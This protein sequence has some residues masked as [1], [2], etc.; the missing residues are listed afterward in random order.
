M[1]SDAIGS[2]DTEL[3]T[4]A[5]LRR[6]DAFQARSFD[7][8][9]AYRYSLQLRDR[10]SVEAGAYQHF[11]NGVP[12]E[13][14]IDISTMVGCPVQ[15]RFCEAASIPFQRAL[16]P[17]EM[18]AQAVK[19]ARDHDGPSFPRIMCSF[20]GIGEPSLVADSVVEA[21]RYLLKHDPRIALSISTMG[22]HLD[23]F[24]RWRASG[25]PIADLQISRSGATEEQASWLAPSAP[26]L[27]DLIQEMD[28]CSRAD[29][30][31]QVKLNYILI[32]GLND[33]DRDIQRLA[34]MFKGT[35]IV[36]KISSLNPT[37]PST[38]NQLLPA[39][40]ARANEVCRALRDNG[41]VS[42]VF[43]TFDDINVSCGQL[44][45]LDQISHCA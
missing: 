34:E 20:Q 41:I 44:T 2:E 40:L 15:C 12:T 37:R 16:Q 30:I 29:T 28:L 21:G 5:M 9:I 36:V 38:R 27:D 42:F 17:L 10:F 31:R 6:E 43:G 39:I 7:Y 45:L 3:V 26:K 32:E 8:Q 35:R 14:A 18:V 23:A 33:T 25:L 11:L 4:V 1:N 19:L 22:T 24:A 13:L